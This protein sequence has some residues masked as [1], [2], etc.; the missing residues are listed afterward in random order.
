MVTRRSFLMYG[1]GLSLAAV[2]P[3]ASAA[4]PRKLV[5]VH[6]RSQE[7]K[8]PD[9]LKATWVE[10][11]RKGAEAANMELPGDLEIA[12]PFYGNVLDEF[13]RQMDLPLTTDIQA[14]GEGAVNEDFLQF[15][16]EIADALRVRRGITDEQVNEEYGE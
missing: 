6:G 1:V 13:T 10:A 12:F 15:Q 2:S 14:R 5:F 4:P 9:V 16:A 8:D 11:L 7:G 3:I